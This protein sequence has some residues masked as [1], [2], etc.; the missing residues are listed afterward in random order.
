MRMSNRV[1]GAFCM[2]LFLL[3]LSACAGSQ[4]QPP[5]ASVSVLPTD[6]STETAVASSQTPAPM[7]PDIIQ[8]VADQIVWLRSTNLYGHTGIKVESEGK[9]I[10][11][12]PVDLVGLE[13]LPKA[14]WIL[15]T[16]DHGDH[17]SIKTIAVL[18]KPE[19]VA[20]S[21]QQ[22]QYS[23]SSVEFFALTPGETVEAGGLQVQG[24]PAYND[25]HP[26]ELGYLG[27]IFTVQGVRIYCSG[28]TGMV[29]ELES[30]SGIDIAVLNIRKPYTFSGEEAVR[31]ARTI[32][33]KILIPIHW[34]PEDETYGDQAEIDYLR[35]N[36]PD[37]TVLMELELMP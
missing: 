28:D 12:D 10:Y 3:P 33:P 4:N 35:Q 14:D 7:D 15:I 1:K 26:K 16:H 11:L 5:T 25:S 29:P 9:V 32:K 30:L 13:N 27:F 21:I 18:S 36:I 34:M 6:L 31:F 20:V 37:T 24:V 8:Q 23:L 19:T 2:V 22:V 17:F